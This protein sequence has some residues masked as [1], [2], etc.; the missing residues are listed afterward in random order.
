MLVQPEISKETR[1]LV[2]NDKL[3]KSFSET[4]R[5]M[6]LA[7]EKRAV[8]RQMLQH[9]STVTEE[10]YTVYSGRHCNR[11]AAMR[12]PGSFR[13]G[14][15]PRPTALVFIEWLFVLIFQVTWKMI[16]FVMYT[17]SL[18]LGNRRVVAAATASPPASPVR[19]APSSPGRATRPP[20][21]PSSPS[22]TA[23]STTVS[24]DQETLLGDT[25][26]GFMRG[27][28]LQCALES[29]IRNRCSCSRV[30]PG[31]KR[32]RSVDHYGD[33]QSSLGLG[34]EPETTIPILSSS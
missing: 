9:Y 28:E 18:V 24:S 22:R 7:L 8:V 5:D 2:E 14:N 25:E 15:H 33:D 3:R 16:G 20:S 21:L 1:T 19:K 31:R 34:D 11:D 10:F 29:K 13:G 30:F 27:V 17:Q 32:K 23:T 6:S 26:K 12:Q 4:S